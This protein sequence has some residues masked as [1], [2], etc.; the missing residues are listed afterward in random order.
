MAVHCMHNTVNMVAIF[1]GPGLFTITNVT[2]GAGNDHI[3]VTYMQVSHVTIYGYMTHITMTSYPC[4][5]SKL[6]PHARVMKLPL[7]AP[8][9]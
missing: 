2:F 6:I 1:S 4:V 5:S 3:N 9:L 7:H 8:S